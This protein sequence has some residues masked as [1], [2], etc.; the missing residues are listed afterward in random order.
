MKKIKCYICNREIKASFLELFDHLSKS[1]GIM[2]VLIKPSHVQYL[3]QL[4]MRQPV[5]DNMATEIWKALEFA[6]KINKLSL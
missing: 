4:L 5:G 2:L 1:H 3:Q 6:Q